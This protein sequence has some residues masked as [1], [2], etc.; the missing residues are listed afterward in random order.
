MPR[1]P[2]PEPSQPPVEGVKD[3]RRHA[4]DGRNA[5]R[6]GEEA[7]PGGGVNGPLQQDRADYAS[8]YGEARYTKA[9]PIPPSTS[10]PPTP[11]ADQTVHGGQQGVL[12]GAAPSRSE[13]H[14]GS[15]GSVPGAGADKGPS[16]PPA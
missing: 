8:H 14:A 9:G 1:K 4:P 6:K 2:K 15:R 7:Y 10:R 3:A 13:G 12:G 11:H 16:D 5:W